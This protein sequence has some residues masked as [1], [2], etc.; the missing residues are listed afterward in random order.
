M[1]SRIQSIS[2]KYFNTSDYEYSMSVVIKIENIKFIKESFV[3][4]II[5]NRT[6]GFGFPKL[7]PDKLGG[8]FQISLIVCHIGF[9]CCI[10]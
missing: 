2:P 7:I 10:F 9:S 5:N 4:A 3:E 8:G 1:T 6:T